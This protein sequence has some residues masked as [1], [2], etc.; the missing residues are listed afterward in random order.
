MAKKRKTSKQIFK[1][2][3]LTQA[4]KQHNPAHT[5]RIIARQRPAM[6]DEMRVARGL[7]PSRRQPL[8]GIPRFGPGLVGPR[9]GPRRV[10]QGLLP[11]SRRPVR[12]RLGSP[13]PVQPPVPPGSVR[14]QGHIFPRGFSGGRI[15]GRVAPWS[16]GPFG[17]R[18]GVRATFGSRRRKRLK[19]KRRK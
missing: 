8:A 15:R 5:S 14:T 18:G 3:G 2:Y 7:V 10:R 9:I 16:P 11:S 4:P 12:R 1:E 6:T 17:R 13:P 19:R